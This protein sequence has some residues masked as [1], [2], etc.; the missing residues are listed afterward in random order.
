MS[1]DNLLKHDVGRKVLSHVGVRL[2]RFWA[3]E[4]AENRVLLLW[5]VLASHDDS[6]SGRRRAARRSA[7]N[8]DFD[9]MP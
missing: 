2:F 8:N 4:E 1:V 3:E 9:V 6:A 7:L 5:A